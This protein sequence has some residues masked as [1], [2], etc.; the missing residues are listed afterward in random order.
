MLDS[1][2]DTQ[3]QSTDW[4]DGAD[5]NDRYTIGFQLSNGSE[6]IFRTGGP[7]EIWINAT[8]SEGENVSEYVGKTISGVTYEAA[9]DTMEAYLHFDDGS[10]L[11]I[12]AGGREMI[13]LE[14]E[15]R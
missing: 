9:C 2:I 6:L 7:G 12:N 3:I 8:V 11:R 5:W 4:T 13:W 10:D 14:V 15:V 1:V